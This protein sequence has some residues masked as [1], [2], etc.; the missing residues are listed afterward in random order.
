[1]LNKTTQFIFIFNLNQKN[2]LS[3]YLKLDKKKKVQQPEL[4]ETKSANSKKHTD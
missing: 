2:K 3:K 4:S 1:M